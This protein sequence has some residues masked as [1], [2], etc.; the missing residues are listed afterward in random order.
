[1]KQYLEHCAQQKMQPIFRNRLQN[2]L[3]EPAPYRLVLSHTRASTR[4]VWI[5]LQALTGSG[6]VQPRSANIL[7]VVG[8]GEPGLGLSALDIANNRLS[9]GAD[10]Y[11]MLALIAAPVSPPISGP[12]MPLAPAAALTELD[13]SLNS[14]GSAGAAALAALLR[15]GR[16]GLRTL[17]AKRTALQDAGCAA[18]AAALG[19]RP[20][21]TNLDL[22][23]NGAA[24]VRFRPGP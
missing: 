13:I 12:A 20:A 4:D 14:L 11:A 17:L 22:S 19:P 7:T 9:A 10:L 15:S 2:F 24:Q 1:M 8:D 18:V 6:C 16:C 3:N 21:L 23:E 5:L